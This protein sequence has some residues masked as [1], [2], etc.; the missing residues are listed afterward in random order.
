MH[1]GFMQ[2]DPKYFWMRIFTD[3]GSKCIANQNILLGRVVLP[4]SSAD[5]LLCGL[6]VGGGDIDSFC[7]VLQGF[8]RG[9]SCEDTEDLNENSFV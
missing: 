7:Q 3:L 1:D 6:P 9:V 5:V 4:A 8:M 2:V